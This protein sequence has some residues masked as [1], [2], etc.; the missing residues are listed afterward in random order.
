MKYIKGKGSG[1]IATLILILIALATIGGHLNFMEKVGASPGPVVY[2]SPV[3]NSAPLNKTFKIDVYIKDASMVH[4][5]RVDMTWDPGILQCENV[6][7]GTWLSEGGTLQTDTIITINNTIGYLQA[8]VSIRGR[9]TVS[10]SGLL[11]T[12]AFEVKSTG[13]T[14]LNITFARLQKRY[15]GGQVVIVYPERRNGY[16]QYP[17][18]EVSVVPNEIFS[19]A[20][21]TFTVNISATNLY[22][23]TSL[24]MNFSWNPEVINLTD[25]IEGDWHNTYPTEFNKT[26]ESSKGIAM[27]NSSVLEGYG[28]CGNKTLVYLTFEVLKKGVSWLNITEPQLLNINGVPHQTIITQGSFMSVPKL[29]TEPSSIVGSHFVPGSEFDLNL[30][31][32]NVDDLN[33]WRL[34]L[35]WDPEIVRLTKV[36]EGPFMKSQFNT[37]FH[38]EI[39]DEEGYMNINCSIPAGKGVNGTGVLAILTFEIKSGG[40]FSFTISDAELL[41]SNGQSI[42]FVAVGT[43]FDNR[44]TDIAVISLSLS[45]EVV[46]PGQTILVNVTVLN[47]GTIPETFNL[48]IFFGRAIVSILTVENLLP[49][50]TRVIPVEINIEDWP[51]DTYT[52]SAKAEFLPGEYDILNNTYLGGSITLESAEEA[53]LNWL[54]ICGVSVAIAIVVIL[55]IVLLKRKTK[56][57]SSLLF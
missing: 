28:A 25:I 6:T 45:Q 44:R 14:C 56:K 17:L 37:T 33:S 43:N 46:K 29:S 36:E 51:S 13:L 34:R 10:G 11:A 49:E 22:N 9:Y 52:V 7:E 24:T 19:S 47:N 16:F 30:T 54:L 21:S 23:L 12:I 39:N 35:G 31:V 38:Y 53:G 18:T 15:P 20:G 26:I 2:V 55:A 1:T 27:V 48:T 8:V 40:A 32:S 57:S 4:T 42:L 3:T 5:W 41:D 50:E